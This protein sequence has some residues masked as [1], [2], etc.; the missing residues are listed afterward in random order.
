MLRVAATSARLTS[1]ALSWEPTRDIFRILLETGCTPTRDHTKSRQRPSHHCKVIL[2]AQRSAEAQVIAPTTGQAI[3]KRPESVL[4]SAPTGL[5]FYCIVHEVG[6][7]S[8]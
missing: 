7:C 4:A 5:D 3:L 1:E 2:Y 6:T 8:T